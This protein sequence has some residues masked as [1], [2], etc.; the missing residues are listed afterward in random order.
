MQEPRAKFSIETLTDHSPPPRLTALG[1][2]A[3]GVAIGLGGWSLMWLAMWLL[4]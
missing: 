3:L 2:V 1:A 4:L